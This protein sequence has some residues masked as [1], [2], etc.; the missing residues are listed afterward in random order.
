MS[1]SGKSFSTRA[2]SIPRCRSFSSTKGRLSRTKFRSSMEGTTVS[3]R[4]R[5]MHAVGRLVLRG[6]ALTQFHALYRGTSLHTIASGLLRAI[7]GL[8]SGKDHPLDFLVP[9]SW[10][11]HADADGH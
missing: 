4:R 9:S 8:V 2:G 10:F 7:E 6:F 3:K 5:R 1:T 11:S